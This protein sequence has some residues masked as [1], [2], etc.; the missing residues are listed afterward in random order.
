MPRKRPLEKVALI[1]VAARQPALPSQGDRRSVVARALNIVHKRRV[2]GSA[3]AEAPAAG[4]TPSPE[5]NLRF[6]GGRTIQSLTYVNLYVGGQSAWAATDVRNIDK[7]LGGA[8]TDPR[9][10]T[11]INQYFT[12]G[13]VATTVAASQIL[14]GPKPSRVSR[15]TI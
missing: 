10:D 8:M 7:G 2:G 15:A 4:L 13:P 11:V 6:R 1:N 12:N 5:N 14:P 9:L 3:S